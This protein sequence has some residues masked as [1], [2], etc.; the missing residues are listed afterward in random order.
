MALTPA[1]AST[2][3]TYDFVSGS[4]PPA[5]KSVIEV[6]CGSG[7]LAALLRENGLKVT[8]IDTDRDAVEAA[9]AVGVDA[10]LVSWPAETD[11]RFDA[12]LFTRSL[13]H[14]EPLE[15]AVF[16]ARDA[17]RPK[18]RIIVEDFRAEG[19][20]E[21]GARWFSDLSRYLIAEGS[22][23]PDTTIDELLKKLAPDGH[24]LHSS[25]A[26]AAALGQIGS[27][28][29]TDAA[30]YFRYLEP[31]LRRPELA[32]DLL[33]QELALIGNGSIKPLGRRFVVSPL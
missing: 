19:G 2:R 14:I 16:A 21:A 33:D 12:I 1:A 32:R 15:A 31:H 8:A 5:A 17:L 20:G 26:I 18:G 10:R 29:A 6:G 11:E 24:D 23:A 22:L 27:V 3:Y 7:Q 4:L 9:I 13:H 25:S 28:D 30:Y